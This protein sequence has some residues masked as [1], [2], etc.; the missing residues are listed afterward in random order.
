MRSYTDVQ[1]LSALSSLVTLG[2]MTWEEV[3]RTLDV[4]RSTLFGWR[5]K[6]NRFMS[7]NDI[8]VRVTEQNIRD[9]ERNSCSWCP[10]ALALMDKGFKAVKVSSLV[11]V[12]LGMD[13]RR[14]R[15]SKNAGDFIHRFDLGTGATPG[16]YRL[17]R[18]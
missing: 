1:R 8:Y 14:Y 13:S 7:S 11:K 5:K 3:S 17:R 4:P 6:F 2:R 9:G 15:L 18:M 12:S 10:L 16:L